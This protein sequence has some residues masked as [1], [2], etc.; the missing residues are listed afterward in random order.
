MADG[1]R[2]LSFHL[3][4]HP[5]SWWLI[6]PLGL[7]DEASLSMVLDTGAPLSGI[8]RRTRDGLAERSLLIPHG[9]RHYLLRDLRIAGQPVPDLVVR[10][11]NRLTEVGADGAVGLDFLNRFTEIHCHIPSLWVTLRR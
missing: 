1:G 5:T 3:L 10:E 6:V 8:S 7:G 9:R 2:E 11:S 4:L